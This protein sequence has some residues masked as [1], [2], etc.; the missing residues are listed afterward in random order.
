MDE[1]YFTQNISSKKGLMDLITL[2]VL[3]KPS[4]RVGFFDGF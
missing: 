4:G 2:Q 3:P 1:S